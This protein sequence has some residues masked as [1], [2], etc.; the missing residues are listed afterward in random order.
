[1]RGY[2]DGAVHERGHE[3]A[4]SDRDEGEWQRE[5]GSGGSQHHH[6]ADRSS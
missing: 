4:G 3:R 6:G 1:M 5:G 2:D